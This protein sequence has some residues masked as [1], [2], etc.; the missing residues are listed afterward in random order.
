MVSGV[1]GW[2]GVCCDFELSAD[3][4]QDR[5]KVSQA[6]VGTAGGSSHLSSVPKSS[7]V[8]S[9]VKELERDLMRR[10]HR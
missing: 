8:I 1:W 10:A 3:D 7:F 6:W 2:Q 5:R 9:G 4:T